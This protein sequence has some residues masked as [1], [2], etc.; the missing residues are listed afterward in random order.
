MRRMDF[1]KKGTV[2]VGLATSPELIAPLTASESG[3]QKP[4]RVSGPSAGYLQRVQGDKFLPKPPA[5]A[6]SVQ[7][8]AIRISPM[9]L[10]GE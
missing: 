9:S 4:S 5:F 3:S 1:L 2:A 7:L 6:E 10:T 8:P